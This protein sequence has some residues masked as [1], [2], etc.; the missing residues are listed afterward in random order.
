[1]KINYK[2]TDQDVIFREHFI[3]S[4][5]DGDSVSEAIEYPASAEVLADYLSRVGIGSEDPSYYHEAF[6]SLVPG[7]DERYIPQNVHFDEINYLAHQI[8]ELNAEQRGIFAAALET[9]RFNR[10]DKLINL[11]ANIVK[12]ELTP[13]DKERLEET[14]GLQGRFRKAKIMKTNAQEGAGHRSGIF[15][16]NDAV[17]TSKGY[18]TQ[19]GEFIEAYRF[20]SDIPQE[21]RAAEY[22]DKKILPGAIDI[23]EQV[24]LSPLVLQLHAVCGDHL[25]DAPS[26]LAT[27]EAMR[28]SEFLL[29]IDE[30]GALLTVAAHVYRE[31]TP[32]YDRF[33]AAEDPPDTYVFALH[34]TDIWTESKPDGEPIRGPIIGDLARID[35]RE[36]QMDIAI[37]TV[38]P[39]M[40]DRE[41]HFTDNDFAYVHRHL[42]RT[43]EHHLETAGLQLKPHELLEEVYY[44]YTAKVADSPEG[45]IIRIASQAAKEMLARDDAPIH[46]IMKSGEKSEN[47]S[48]LDVI[49]IMKF[50]KENTFAIKTEDLSGFDKWAKRTASEMVRQAQ[51]QTVE[52]D[53]SKKNRNTEH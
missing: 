27:L 6:E 46:L 30:R 43:H 25:A 44:S 3:Y 10:M 18:L 19:H 40:I 12:F 33:M 36:Q 26:N 42:E 15:D 20:L 45:G 53:A 49:R 9:G 48:Q 35:L 11:A 39:E 1:M 37:H 28:S 41:R 13:A 31:G 50:G 52:R 7:I 8:Q 47:L 24:E 5:S 32:Q 34:V 22:L 14:S 29:L 21:L 17:L 23:V 4:N 2:M 51:T 38:K 16:A